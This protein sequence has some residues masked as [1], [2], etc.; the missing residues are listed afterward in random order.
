M[1]RI[2]ILHF[3]LPWCDL[4]MILK[5]YYCML[6]GAM[7]RSPMK[8][9]PSEYEVLFIFVSRKNAT[10]RAYPQ[11]HS[12]NL[13]PGTALEDVFLHSIHRTLLQVWVYMYLLLGFDSGNAS[14]LCL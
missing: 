12:E 10:G 2:C 13:M 8:R 3:S 4:W 14:L 6:A 5:T 7:K 9:I 11:R 1:S